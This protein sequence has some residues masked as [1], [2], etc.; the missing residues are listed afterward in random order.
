M[1][2]TEPESWV[3]RPEKTR[4]EVLFRDMVYPEYSKYFLFW[5]A[6]SGHGLM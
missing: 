2:S 6:S 5:Y 4:L 3:R 1:V